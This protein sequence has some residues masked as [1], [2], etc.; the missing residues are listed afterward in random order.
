MHNLASGDLSFEEELCSLLLSIDITDLIFA[1][2]IKGN[3]TTTPHNSTCSQEA[4]TE[5]ITF[6]FVL[7]QYFCWQGEK[8]HSPLQCYLK[9]QMVQ[10]RAQL[11]QNRLLFSMGL[12]LIDIVPYL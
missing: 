3:L 10:G 9:F 8:F 6:L 5:K 7:A 1:S 12:I 11:W 4:D 2:P